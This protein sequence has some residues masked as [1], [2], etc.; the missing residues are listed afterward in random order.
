M[1]ACCRCGDVKPLDQYAK[2]HDAKDGRGSACKSCVKTYNADYRI[3]NKARLAERNKEWRALNAE[4]IIADKKRMYAANAETERAKA[5]AY[6]EANK[7]ETLQKRRDYY[8]RNRD[9][10]VETVRLWRA[11]FGAAWGRGYYA[12]NR[13]K[14]RAKESARRA[15]CKRATPAWANPAEIEAFYETADALGMW[16]GEWY[17]VDHIVPLVSKKVCGLHVQANMQV[18]PKS[19]NARKRNLHWPDM[20]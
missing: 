19:E 18:L 10:C 8:S 20:F 3:A 2:K 12:K 14:L 15:Q 6:R 9:A 5:K 11:E 17:E 13:S 7:E 4:R 1:K 16:T